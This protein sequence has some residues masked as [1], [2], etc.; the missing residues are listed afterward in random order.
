[1]RK[2]YSVSGRCLYYVKHI[3]IIAFVCN[4]KR[5]AIAILFF[6]FFFSLFLALFLDGLAKALCECLFNLL[7]PK[8]CVTSIEHVSLDTLANV[9]VGVLCTV[10]LCV[11]GQYLFNMHVKF[12]GV[13]SACPYSSKWV[14]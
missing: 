12:F 9:F 8:T 10:T 2:S 1:M 3:F 5:F 13:C 7:L 11:G 6:F 4:A 14:S